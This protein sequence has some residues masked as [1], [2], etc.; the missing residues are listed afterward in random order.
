MKVRRG[1]GAEMGAI[2]DRRGRRCT[3]V[4]EDISVRLLVLARLKAPRDVE[5]TFK[6][7]EAIVRIWLSRQDGRG[8]I[9]ESVGCADDELTA[10]ALTLAL[11]RL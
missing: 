5:A 2:A 9:L 10:A 6:P 3:P 4:D 11:I 1:R 7:K 8:K